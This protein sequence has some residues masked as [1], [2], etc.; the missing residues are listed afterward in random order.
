MPRNAQGD[1][2][3]QCTVMFMA[4]FFPLESVHLIPFFLEK[5]VF[6]IKFIVYIDKNKTCW[7]MTWEAA[8]VLL[9]QPK[10]R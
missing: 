9:T 4:D 7:G 2:H 3:K 5:G 8:S 1:S 6:K 10:A